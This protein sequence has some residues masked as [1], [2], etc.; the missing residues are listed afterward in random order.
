[1]TET[2]VSLVWAHSSP[3]LRKE[4]R[5]FSVHTMSIPAYEKAWET[6][7]LPVSKL[8][9][10]AL[11]DRAD[12]KGFCW[13]SIDD[14]KKRTGLAKRSVINHVAILEE[15]GFLRVYREHRKSN[16]Y[17]IMGIVSKL[18]S[19]PRAPK[20]VHAVHPTGAPRAPQS[21]GNRNL[22]HQGNPPAEKVDHSEPVNRQARSAADILAGMRL[23]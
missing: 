4:W 21:S 23:R 22:N 8:V 5:G 11:A 17:R 15:S 12:P 10:L 20:V 9:L 18:D 1:M 14:I 2:G 19:A 6:K 7:C 13:P 16:R 3:P